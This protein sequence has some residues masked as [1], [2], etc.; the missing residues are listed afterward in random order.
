M[1]LPEF[2]KAQGIEHDPKAMEEIFRRTRD[3]AYHIIQRKG[4]TFFAVAAGLVRIPEAILRNQNT[5]LSV[6]SLVD[7]YYE[8]RDVCL[9]LPTV[10][11][12]KG[13]A[14]VLRIRLSDTEADQLRKSAAVL[15]RT[16]STLKL[17]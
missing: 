17:A 6:S 2:C 1:K 12:R 16:A 15:Q 10:V 8:I 14:K 5:V 7:D 13:V 11:N 9:S 3:A 4:A